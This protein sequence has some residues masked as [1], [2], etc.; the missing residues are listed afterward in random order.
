M[1]RQRIY[2][3][4]KI[5]VSLADWDARI[6]REL[7]WEA[8]REQLPLGVNLLAVHSKLQEVMGAEWVAGY[9]AYVIAYDML[10]RGVPA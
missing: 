7:G 3:L 8:A 6:D 2:E 9:K 1:T 4:G 10:N 5:S